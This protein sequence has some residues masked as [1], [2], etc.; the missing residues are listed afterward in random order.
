M[1]SKQQQA[2]LRAIVTRIEELCESPR[3]DFDT[4]NIVIR[5]QGESYLLKSKFATLTLGFQT[6]ESDKLPP[7]APVKKKG[8]GRKK[9]AAAPPV[10]KGPALVL[11]GQAGAR[12]HV[13]IP[14]RLPP[15]PTER[16]IEAK[17][18]IIL[19]LLAPDVEYR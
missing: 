16:E 7:K 3:W 1:P 18:R 11:Q 17:V 10:S 8:W 14:W 15:D 4:C 2:V 12:S 9:T 5:P 6:R 19:S 13:D